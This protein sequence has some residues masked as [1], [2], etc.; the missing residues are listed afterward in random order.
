MELV[1]HPALARAR[2]ARRSGENVV[3]PSALWKLADEDG[4]LYRHAM[5]EAGM[6]VDANTMK[7]FDP[8]PDCGWSLAGE[9]AVRPQGEDAGNV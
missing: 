6:L 5:K 7:P 3:S 1:V 4:D 2:E 8:C 9:N